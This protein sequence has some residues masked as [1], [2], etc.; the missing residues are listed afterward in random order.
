MPPAG[1]R[2]SRSR[3]RRWAGRA[4]AS[5]RPQDNRR[6]T[7]GARCCSSSP[8]W[9]ACSAHAAPGA[10]WT[11]SPAWRGVNRSRQ[12]ARTSRCWSRPRSTTRWCATTASAS[13]ACRRTAWPAGRAPRSVHPWALQREAGVIGGTAASCLQQARARRWRRGRRGATSSACPGRRARRRDRT[14]AEPPCW[15]PMAGAIAFDRSRPADAG[16]AAARA[17]ADAARAAARDAR[18]PWPR[19]R[20]CRGAC[21]ALELQNRCA[22]RAYAEIRLGAEEPRPSRSPAYRS[23]LEANTCIGCSKLIWASLGD[24][25]ALA[26]LGEAQQRERVERCRCRGALGALSTRGGPRSIDRAFGGARACPRDRRGAR[27]A[28]A[29]TR[30]RAVSRARTRVGARDADRRARRSG[31]G[32]T[33]STA[34]EDGRLAVLDYKTGAARQLDWLGERAEPVQLFTYRTGAAGAGEAVRSPPSARCTW[35]GVARCSAR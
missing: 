30:A 33:G 14:R 35:C 13:A 23:W 9:A 24:S 17:G 34:F 15:R 28:G 19:S 27:A 7:A 31:C 25:V 11:C 21:G 18:R 20:C 32:S 1:P 16:R 6:S 12:S 4:A 10:R 5:R 29:R 26:A 8:I 3:S 22:F 2:P